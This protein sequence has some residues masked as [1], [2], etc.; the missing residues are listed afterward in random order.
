MKQNDL[1]KIQNL[2][3]S[4]RKLLTAESNSIFLIDGRWKIYFDEKKSHFVSRIQ[5]L[6]KAEHS[7]TEE[8]YAID[9]DNLAAYQIAILRYVVNE[10]SGN[11]YMELSL[12]DSGRK[13]LECKSVVGC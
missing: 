12:H 11:N 8:V 4:H 13:I 1:E 5:N 6:E 9:L 3:E 2:T 7:F 10:V